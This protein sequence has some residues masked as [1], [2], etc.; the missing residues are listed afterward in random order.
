[1]RTYGCRRPDLYQAATCAGV[2][3]LAL[4]PAERLPQRGCCGFR[5][6]ER[7]IG[8]FGVRGQLG[9]DGIT[10]D[11]RVVHIGDLMQREVTGGGHVSTVM[12]LQS[13][14]FGARD[15]RNARLVGVERRPQRMP[16]HPAS[17]LRKWAMSAAVSGWS[18]RSTHGGESAP[19]PV[20]KV[21]PQIAMGAA[22]GQAFFVGQVLKHGAAQWRVFQAGVQR[23]EVCRKGGDMVPVLGRVLAQLIARKLA[24]RPCL[25]EGVLQQ[26]VA[27]D[28]GI[29]CGKELGAEKDSDMEAAPV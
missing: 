22:R 2:P 12:L 5:R 24:L 20:A 23:A 18:L 15:G 11:L 17:R 3:A 14:G 9:L 27:G 28:A 7:G 4:D 8:L 10:P 13:L 29:E 25:I 19:I 1:M 26:I 21:H 16:A 6:V